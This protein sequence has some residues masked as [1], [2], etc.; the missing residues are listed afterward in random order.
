MAEDNRTPRRR[1]MFPDRP[2]EWAAHLAK[3]VAARKRVGWTPESRAALSRKM[4]GKRNP[5]AERPDSKN[6]GTGRSRARKLTEHIT[7]CQLA[8][9]GGCDGVIDRAHVDQDPLNNDLDNIMVLCRSHHRLYDYGWI[10]LSNPVM[11]EIVVVYA[12][13][14][15]RYRKR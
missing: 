13:G 10:D 1:R 6:I 5:W 4:K 2:E 7:E 15:R 11:P 8:H 3:M 14:K 9:I 12:N